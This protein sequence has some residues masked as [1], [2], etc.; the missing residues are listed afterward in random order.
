MIGRGCRSA[1]K[2]GWAEG[3]ATGG[4]IHGRRS[5]VN[6]V[7]CGARHCSDPDTIIHGNTRAHGRGCGGFSAAVGHCLRQRSGRQV[8]IPVD[9]FLHFYSCF[10]WFCIVSRTNTK[11]QFSG[12][13][14]N[15]IR[16]RSPVVGE[17]RSA[18]QGIR[19]PPG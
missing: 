9:F 10:H 2:T 4:S 7:G 6:V 19:L 11:R 5:Y 16:L 1:T 3:F 15:P 8:L 17:G 18:G 12:F 14:W 13:C